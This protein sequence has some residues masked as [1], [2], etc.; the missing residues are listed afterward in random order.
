MCL[1]ALNCVIQRNIN[2]VHYIVRAF[3][4]N[5]LF[6]RLGHD[7]I[8]SKASQNRNRFHEHSEYIKMP[9]ADAFEERGRVIAKFRNSTDLYSMS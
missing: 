1:R 2:S 5:L 8:L 3:K 9:H 4:N 6:D 7:N